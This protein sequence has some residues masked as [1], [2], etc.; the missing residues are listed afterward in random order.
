MPSPP[1]ATPLLES[2]W[3][4]S[5]PERDYQ[6]LGRVVKMLAWMTT[7][8]AIGAALL[9]LGWGD[10]H[11]LAMA[12][13]LGVFVAWIRWA[14]PR[15]PERGGGWFVLRGAVAILLLVASLLVILPQNGF[16]MT[17]LALIPVVV[18]LP[19]LERGSMGRLVIV[20]WLACVGLAIWA[21]LMVWTDAG[22]APSPVDQ[23]M[24][25]VGIASGAA[26]ILVLLW[27]HH[28]RLS[29]SAKELG[30]VVA[31]SRD[32]AQV[33]DPEQLGQRM[34][35]H[36][37][38]A[39]GADA[40]VISHWDVEADSLVPFGRHPAN[41][42]RWSHEPAGSVPVPVRRALETGTPVLLDVT[43]PGTDPA[44]AAWVV[45]RGHLAMLL[46]PLAVQG[47]TIGIL[48]LACDRTRLGP[49]AAARARTLAGEAAMALENA[50]LYE[51][52]RHQ[53]FHDNL[54][55]LANR[56][57]FTDRLEHALA[58]RARNGG[59]VAVLFID[60]DDFKAINDR[61][62]HLQGDQLLREVGARLLGCLRMGDTAARVG[63]DEFA[64]LLED[65][66]DRAEA[67]LIARRIVDAMEPPMTLSAGQVPAAVSIGLCFSDDG[68]ATADTLL[69]NA[70]FAM[71]RA[72][73]VGKGRV[74]VFRPS[75][76][77]GV[78]ERLA[79]EVALQGAA[80][81][82]ELRL[83]YQPIVDLR[84][85]A[86]SGLEALV[87]WQS[88]THGW[89]MPSDFIALAEDTGLIV[90][91]GRWVLLEAC[92]Q[93]RAW[94]RLL[95]RD[96]LTVSVNI[97]AR[98]FQ[99]H[100]LADDVA[101]ALEASGLSPASLVMEL[102]ESVLM[103][104]TPSTIATLQGLRALGVRVAIDD[105]GTGYSSLSYLQR[106][107]VDVLKIDRSFVEAA[108]GGADGAALVRAIVEIGAAL[109][110]RVVAEGIERQDQV[111]TLTAYGCGHGQG[112]LFAHALDAADAEA[113]L[114]A[115]EPPWGSVTPARRRASAPRPM[116]ATP[117][118]TFS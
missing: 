26:A 47:E 15:V 109:H 82:E 25:V 8:I 97:S 39:T 104:H 118:P 12:L 88:P 67:E 5:D 27:Q 58:R 64:V 114:S 32:L 31:M 40:C 98:Q 112:F 53:A 41:A 90:T 19:Y 48:E 63:G 77:A 71:Y 42:G 16:G 33:R 91:I 9:F 10:V 56:A 74:E 100:A 101:E 2:A 59:L 85:G 36:L 65:V 14:W 13:V 87:R 43:V 92:R 107:P 89:R 116:T 22:H 115:P 68:G 105:F 4:T 75:M 45:E 23:L 66:A 24:R 102:T 44:E 72:K 106:F 55:H 3:P 49:R 84:T 80:E 103:A 81:R 35:E 7:G 78:E 18:G 83:Q 86:I 52:L 38:G 93:T 60:V 6:Q 117:T 28:A 99:H 73:S 79:L 69:R 50:R 34:A 96:D 111:T 30:T 61:M 20:A 94:Q 54:T 46:V 70:D 57:L 51:E 29:E 37:A 110:L 1:R 76:R 108:S 17:G 62:G 95:G 113:L 21:E 11:L